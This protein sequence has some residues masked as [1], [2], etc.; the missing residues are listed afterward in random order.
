MDIEELHIKF[1]EIIE[2]YDFNSPQKAQELTDYIVSKSSHNA[3]DLSEHFIIEIEEAKVILEFLKKGVE[4]K[5]S[6]QTS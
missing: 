4:F 2:K 1:K 6:I 5:Y 3:Q